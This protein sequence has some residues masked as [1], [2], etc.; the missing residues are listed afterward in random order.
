M[1]DCPDSCLPGNLIYL[2]ATEISRYRETRFN[3]NTHLSDPINQ[4]PIKLK[5]PIESILLYSYNTPLTYDYP[6]KLFSHKLKEIDF[7]D[8]ASS[9]V[10]E[11]TKNK[12][13]DSRRYF[14]FDYYSS[15]LKKNLKIVLPKL[16]LARDLF[17]S[18]PYLLRAAL[19]AENYSTDIVVDMDDPAAIHIFIAKNKKIFKQD[20]SDPH[21]LKKLALILL[22]P[23]LNRAFLSIYKRT[24]DD[25]K[26]F[27]SLIFDM[28]APEINNIDLAVNGIY[29]PHT[30]IYKI[31][32]ITSFTNLETH[33][34]RPIQ[35][36]FSSKKLLQLAKEFQGKSSKKSKIATQDKTQLDRKA[37]ADIDK[38]LTKLRNVIGEI[39]TVEELNIVLETPSAD[40]QALR[41]Y[42]QLDK[43]NDQE[44]GF[45]GGEGDIEGTLPGFTNESEIQ[46]ERATHQDLLKVLKEVEQ[47]GYEVKEIKNS[48]FKKYKRFRGHK[49]ANNQ[50]RY[51]YIYKISNIHTNEQFY[52][53]EIDTSDGK[54]NI[55][56]LLLKYDEQTRLL[57]ERDL[58]KF[59]NS[60]LSQSLS[61]PKKLLSEVWGISTFTTINHPSKKE[62]VEQ[63]NYYIDWAQR[64]IEKL[65]SI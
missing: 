41:R 4:R 24:I 43:D 54:K 44:E 35:F 49:F 11:D 48:P 23:E 30:S 34:D 13:E 16:V 8:F 14:M 31:E 50:L 18:H 58:E 28:D 59:N 10:S 15:K 26:N 45:A 52:F 53:C 7:S 39:Y 12:G 25:Q 62:Q 42:K 9:S 27:K 3:I 38:V 60:I 46:L 36:H 19:F 32:R 2:I 65:K 63:L 29:N 1:S 57:I 33:I 21:F 40:I 6:K 61:W 64:I 5:L 17:F 20:L 22:H 47:K 37:D 55:S 51:F 56:T